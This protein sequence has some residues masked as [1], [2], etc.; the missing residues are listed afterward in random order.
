M[1]T[2]NDKKK[3]HAEKNTFCLLKNL[4]QLLAVSVIKKKTFLKLESNQFRI[5]HDEQTKNQNLRLF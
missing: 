4:F 5:T 2:T 1:N 3:T